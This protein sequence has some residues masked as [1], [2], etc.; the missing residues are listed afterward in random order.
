[1]K[2]DLRLQNWL[3]QKNTSMRSNL[4]Y[5]KSLLEALTNS[6]VIILQ[7]IGKPFVISNFYPFTTGILY[8]ECYKSASI[9]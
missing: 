7:K 9:V 5:L 4:K 6:G 3:Q 2:F 8:S 1:M